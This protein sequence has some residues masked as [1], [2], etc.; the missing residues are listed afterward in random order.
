M[1]KEKIRTK[2]KYRVMI[3]DDHPTMRCG[4]ASLINDE[5]DLEVCGEASGVSEALQVLGDCDADLVIVDI[6]LKDG[7]GIEL[8]EQIRARDSSI[9][10]LV[11]SMHDEYLYT[12]RALRAG[13]QGYIN[14]QE[15]T[16]KI[17][18]AIRHVLSGKIFLSSHMAERMLH[19]M[20][21]LGQVTPAQASIDSLSNRELEVFE[22]IGKGHATRRIAE[23]LHLSV[24]T[25]E[26]H[27][28]NIKKKLMLQTNQE[29]VRR[30]VQWVL[31]QG[32]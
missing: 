16:D 19:H 10:I 3:V 14:K 5:P 29:L 7:N 28:E 15:A 23:N 4:L 9:R 27:R 6:T 13:A 12:D 2:E 32:K 24:K 30:S 25:I 26:S 18:E 22:L 21:G 1:P 20:V 11:S 17:V 8:I 31:E